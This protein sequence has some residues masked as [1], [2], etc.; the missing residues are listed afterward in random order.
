LDEV[1]GIV[2]RMENRFIREL[3]PA[4]AQES[5]LATFVLLGL[6]YP[7]DIVQQLLT[8][9]RQMRESTTY[10]WIIEQGLQEGRQQG[11]QQGMQQGRA[12][13]EARG[14]LR[15]ARGLLLRLG[16]R[17]FG[18]PPPAEALT[19]IDQLSDVAEI[20]SL[21]ERVL[22]AASWNDLFPAKA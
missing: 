10:Q 5:W 11:I 15:E 4:E 21:V 3:S 9:V 1:P 12:E 22:V 20:E 18:A 6:R 19:G 14:Q 7:K 8:G 13:G 17:Q 2:K 16:T